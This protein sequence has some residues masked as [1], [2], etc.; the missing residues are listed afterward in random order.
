MID[1]SEG[2]DFDKLMNEGPAIFTTEL[3]SG[4]LADPGTTREMASS[5][6][7]SKTAG[8][9]GEEV[10]NYR[11]QWVARVEMA[12]PTE[13]S[14]RTKQTQSKEIHKTTSVEDDVPDAA[15]FG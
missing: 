14:S 1:E 7:M 15:L 5:F 8:Y 13:L 4:A 12:R 6:V 2:Q 11:Q 10:E 3:D 9:E